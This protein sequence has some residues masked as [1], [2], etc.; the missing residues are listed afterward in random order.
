LSA[1]L[2]IGSVFSAVR[3]Y[4]IEMEYRS[5]IWA[6]DSHPT[7]ETLAYPLAY[8]TLGDKGD[9]LVVSIGIHR[10]IL[11]EVQANL[12]RF[13]L[14]D[15]PLL[16]VRGEQPI[17]SPEQANV[18]VRNVKNIIVQS[19]LAAGSRTIHLFYGGPAHLALF[20]GYRLDATAPIVCYGWVGNS[21]YSRTCQLFSYQKAH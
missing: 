7:A 10:N 11:S 21:Q 3:G 1:C 2:A 14:S 6:S 8:Q 17:T 18:V 12:E 20:L 19:L 5:E 16:D 4:A 15:A 9:C 13:G